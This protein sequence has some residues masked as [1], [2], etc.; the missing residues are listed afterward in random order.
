MSE[1][2]LPLI[3]RFTRVNCSVVERALE[4]KK[5]QASDDEPRWHHHGV[6]STMPGE[7][8]LCAGRVTGAR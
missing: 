7:A 3:C 4:M 6:R 8:I 1:N 5:I 2:M